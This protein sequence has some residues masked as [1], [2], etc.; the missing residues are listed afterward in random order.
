MKEA[1]LLIHVR[2]GDCTTQV[3]QAGGRGGVIAL[4]TIAPEKLLVSS[5]F[6]L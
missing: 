5:D 1:E 4:V 3:E 6:S 2:L